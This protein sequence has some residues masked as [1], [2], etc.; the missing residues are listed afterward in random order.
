V[1]GERQAT[2]AVVASASIEVRN[3]AE[4]PLLKTE[5]GELSHKVGTDA[6][7]NLPIPCA[8]RVSV[9]DS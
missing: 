1:S 7:D 2:G 3:A 6:L 8:A 9:P 5:S 4:S